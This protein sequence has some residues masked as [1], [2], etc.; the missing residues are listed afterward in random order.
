MTN[1]EGITV[2]QYF[3]SNCGVSLSSNGTEALDHMVSEHG[4]DPDKPPQPNTPYLIPVEANPK[5]DE[6]GVPEV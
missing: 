4:F 5:L 2:T 1:S 3:C 6:N